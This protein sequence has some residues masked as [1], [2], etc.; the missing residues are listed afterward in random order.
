[1]FRTELI[2]SASKDK[3]R[4]GDEFYLIGS[5]FAGNIGNLLKTFKF[6][7]L[8]NPFG[9]IYNPY[10]IFKLLVESISDQALDEKGLFELQGIFR[11]FDFHSDISAGSKD[12]FYRLHEEA[13]K[14]TRE[15]LAKADWVIISLG[16]SIVFEHQNYQKIVANSHKLPGSE[17]S[18]RMLVPEEII[19]SFDS[20]YKNLAQ[21][22]DKARIILTVSPVRHIRSTLEENSLSKAVLRYTAGRLSSVYSKVVYFPSFEIMM[23]DLRDYRFYKQDMIHPNETAV[24]YIWGKFMDTFFDPEATAFVHHWTEIKK[25]LGHKPFYP[26]S[27]A[28]QKFIRETIRKIKSFEPRVDIHDELLQLENQLL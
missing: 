26:E 5:C 18:R 27:K 7:V 13:A 2:P 19:A 15:K 9:V 4:P 17:F 21:V 12:A 22:N 28:H 24:D 11:H 10:S 20:F 25:A 8:L 3:I 6:K 14:H 16:T 1:M 23:D